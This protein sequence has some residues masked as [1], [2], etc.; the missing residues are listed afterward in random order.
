[1]YKIKTNK[2]IIFYFFHF[3]FFWHIYFTLTYILKNKTKQKHKQANKIKDKFMTDTR[4]N[5]PILSMS[6]TEYFYCLNLCRTSDFWCFC[7]CFVILYF[8]LFF[9]F[10]FVFLFHLRWWTQ[11]QRPPPPPWGRRSKTW[12]TEMW[13]PEDPFSRTT[14]LLFARDPFHGKELKSYLTGPPLRK[15]WK[16]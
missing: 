14:L 4:T 15:I 13:I 12:G 16:F 10:L 6:K 1:M 3:I 5:R 11:A 7:C 2:M 8:V 9:C